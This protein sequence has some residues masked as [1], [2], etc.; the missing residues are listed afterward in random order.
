[1]HTEKASPP[2]RVQWLKMIAARKDVYRT[3][4]AVLDTCQ[5]PLP[6]FCREME[7]L[8]RADLLI[9]EGYAQ[10]SVGGNDNINTAL[11]AISNRINELQ[12]A[13]DAW[14]YNAMEK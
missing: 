1:M 5:R 3:Y 7:V 9:A 13:V 14:I 11:K 8:V 6:D 12:P 2:E 4:N 10:A